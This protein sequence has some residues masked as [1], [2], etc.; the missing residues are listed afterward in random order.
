M[1]AHEAQQAET[2]ERATAERQRTIEYCTGPSDGPCSSHA[3]KAVAGHVQR[4][5]VDSSTRCIRSRLGVSI[6]IWRSQSAS[7]RLAPRSSLRRRPAPLES[8][9]S[10]CCYCAVVSSVVRGLEPGRS[11]SGSNAAHGP[12]LL[13]RR[14][15]SPSRP[16]HCRLTLLVLSPRALIRPLSGLGR[17]CLSHSTRPCCSPC[18]P[19]P[20]RRCPSAS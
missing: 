19:V 14:S 9:R 17:L 16:H 20:S 11:G 15:Y 4:H 2:A 7:S 18:A 3:A 12:V 8:A 1:K 10:C 6:H 13:D 5:H